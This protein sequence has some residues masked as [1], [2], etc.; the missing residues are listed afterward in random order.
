ML[1]KLLGAT[2]ALAVISAAL[3]WSTPRATVDAVH[4]HP[5][6]WD[7][8]WV[9]WL[10][11]TAMFFTVVLVVCPVVALWR[12]GGHVLTPFFGFV[13]S[14]SVALVCVV[15]G[16]ANGDLRGWLM[17]T[18]GVA[19]FVSV[20]G[21]ILGPFVIAPVVL[22]RRRALREHVEGDPPVQWPLQS[23]LRRRKVDRDDRRRSRTIFALVIILAVATSVAVAWLGTLGFAIGAF[24]ALLYLAGHSLGAGNFWWGATTGTDKRDALSSQLANKRWAPS[25]AEQYDEGA[26]QRARAR[27]GLS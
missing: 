25:D 6:I 2:F 5:W 20:G 1:R 11:C 15:Y 17:N 7:A 14:L 9:A 13:F 16:A 18:I 22:S 27:R 12:R 21:L 10:V 3:E 8:L 4:R 26:W 19:L 23:L 24:A